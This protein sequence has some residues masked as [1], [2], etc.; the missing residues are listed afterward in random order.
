MVK[1]LALNTEGRI[2]YCT[3]DPEMRG[4]GRCNHIEHQNEGETASEFIERISL[5]QKEI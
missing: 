4:R 2:T 3:V 5:K 1:M